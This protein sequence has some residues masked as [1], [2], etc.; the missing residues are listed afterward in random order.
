MIK[1]ISIIADSDIGNLIEALAATGLPVISEYELG[2]AIFL[3]LSAPAEERSEL[4]RP[5]IEHLKTLKIF[6]PLSLGGR[7]MPINSSAT[8]PHRLSRS[9]VPWTRLLTYPI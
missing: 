1:K 9:H 6:A 7:R 2:R 8:Q 5:V 3:K 4:F